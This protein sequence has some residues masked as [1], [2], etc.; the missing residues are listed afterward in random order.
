MAMRCRNHRE[1][2]TTGCGERIG[3]KAT[4][5]GVKQLPDRPLAELP[6]QGRV[7]ELGKLQAVERPTVVSISLSELLAHPVQG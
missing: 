7:H 2:P 5:D 1:A 3:D 6:P 4:I